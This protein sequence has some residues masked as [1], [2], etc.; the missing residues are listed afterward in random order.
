[1]L[2][3]KLSRIPAENETFVG[4]PLIVICGR[5]TVWRK[6]EL[7]LLQDQLVGWNRRIHKP[8]TVTFTAEALVR[9]EMAARGMVM[10]AWQ[11]YSPPSD[12]RI[13]LNVR[14]RLDIL[15][16]LNGPSTSIFSPEVMRLPLEYRHS[17]AGGVYKFSTTVTL[18][19]R[20]SV[21]PAVGFPAPEMLT[22]GGGR[23]RKRNNLMVQMG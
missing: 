5:G 23:S 10:L 22:S 3:V 2:Q 8:C 11:L 1:M 4:E 7:K 21:S 6:Y 14:V 17:M 20:L 9:S 12:V 19:V 15:P 13:W 16:E 18:H